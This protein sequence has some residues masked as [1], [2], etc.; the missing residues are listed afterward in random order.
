MGGKLYPFPKG[1]KM[2]GTKEAFGIQLQYHEKIPLFP[3][4]SMG[5]PNIALQKK[6]SRVYTFFFFCLC[7][8][9]EVW[10]KV[11]ARVELLGQ[12]CA[13]RPVTGDK[14]FFIANVCFKPHR[15][16][17]L[18]HWKIHKCQAQCVNCHSASIGPYLSIPT[19]HCKI[20]I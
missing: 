19:S 12:R 14:S 5:S 15:Y 16:C 3:F 6:R 7:S 8:A 4:L 18:A 13:A 2:G 10:H 17:H 9:E 20:K 11:N 1:E